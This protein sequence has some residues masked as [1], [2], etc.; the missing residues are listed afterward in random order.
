MQFCLTNPSFH[1]FHQII[2]YDFPNKLTFKVSINTMKTSPTNTPALL[3]WLVDCV[4]CHFQQYFSY[5]VGISFMGGG[6]RRKPDL[7][8]VTDTD[9]LYHI[10]LHQVHLAMKEFEL[11]VL[12]AI[13]TDC[14]GSCKSNYHT[15]TTALLNWTIFIL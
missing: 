5:I 3:N 2:I 6:N 8:Q 14:S 13:G 11:T 1:V 9:K 4:Q 7:L 10:M 12:V 15:I